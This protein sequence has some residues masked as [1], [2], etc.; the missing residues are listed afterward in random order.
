MIL[1][2]FYVSVGAGDFPRM[3]RLI[4]AFAARIAGLFHE[5][6]YVSIQFIKMQ[7]GAT[8]NLFHGQG[9]AVETTPGF[10]RRF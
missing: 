6:K 3:R 10:N 9:W 2:S 8:I 4:W 7:N 5:I 1:H